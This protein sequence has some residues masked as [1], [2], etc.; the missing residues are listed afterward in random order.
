MFSKNFIFRQQENL[1]DNQKCQA[2]FRSLCNKILLFQIQFHMIFLIIWIVMLQK[3]Y[4]ITVLQLLKQ[5]KK[6]TEIS[7]IYFGI[8]QNWKYLQ[9][10]ILITSM[11]LQKCFGL[12]VRYYQ[13]LLR[14]VTTS[15]LE[16]WGKGIFTFNLPMSKL[17]DLEICNE[18]RESKISNMLYVNAR[19][20]CPVNFLT[21]YGKKVDGQ[22]F[23][24]L[25]WG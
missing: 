15:L 24:S 11:W 16:K 13:G 3:M 17:F 21:Y 20:H 18:I 22:W 12:I 2:G 23:R 9:R 14:Q 6:L 25:F 8:R 5:I 1:V 7:Y 4:K 19:N 10:Y